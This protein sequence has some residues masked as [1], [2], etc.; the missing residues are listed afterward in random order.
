MLY[1]RSYPGCSFIR[2]RMYI[3][4]KAYEAK[5]FGAKHFLSHRQF[6]VQGLGFKVLGL[7]F[8]VQFIGGFQ[9]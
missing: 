7:G 8:G 2:L 4:Q 1:Y 3:S 9:A 6:G 5:S